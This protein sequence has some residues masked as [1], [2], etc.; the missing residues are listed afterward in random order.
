MGS[1][2]NSG[3]FRILIVRV[4]YYFG[5]DPDFKNYPGHAPLVSE[6]A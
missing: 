4:P 5:D 6:A 1:S 2:L 3:P